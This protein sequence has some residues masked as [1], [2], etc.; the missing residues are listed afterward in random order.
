MRRREFMSLSSLAALAP[1]SA[2]APVA[3]RAATAPAATAPG[4]AAA[5]PADTAADVNDY[6]L[7]P[8]DLTSAEH[9]EVVAFEQLR[10][11]QARGGAVP[12]TRG[13]PRRAPTYRLVRWSGE[14]GDPQGAFAGPLSVRPALEAGG[15]A[16]RLNAQIVG[17][18][19]G[20][21]DWGR[22]ARQGTLTVEFRGRAKGEALTWLF[23]KQFDVFDGGSS[24]LGSEYVAQHNNQP[25]PVVVDDPFVDLRIQLIRHVR[26]PTFLRAVLNLASFLAKPAVGTFLQAASA[27]PTPSIRVP[28]LVPEG[29]ALTQAVLGNSADEKPLWAS[30][31]NSYALTAVGSRMKLAPGYWVAYDDS[32]EGDL[33]D[34]RLVEDGDRV[35]LQRGGQPID[36][37]YLVL[38]FEVSSLAGRTV[39][40]APPAAVPIPKSAPPVR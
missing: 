5:S 32:L 19:L 31:F 36:A 15:G 25:E 24:N 18:Q 13:R 30:G 35:A 17:F 1:L 26:K 10:D 20:S 38:L 6:F 39:E 8:G 9:E 14:P 23:A 12:A 11:V 7:H 16:F 40:S 34:V 2:L 22:S 33:R 29:V 28:R 3:A 27:T 4:P 21:D 37:N